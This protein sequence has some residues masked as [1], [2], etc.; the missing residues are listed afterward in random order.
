M[1]RRT[2]EGMGGARLGTGRRLGSQ[3]W[4]PPEG[5]WPQVLARDLLSTSTMATAMRCSDL[6]RRDHELIGEVVAEVATLTARLREGTDAPVSALAGAIEFFTAFVSGV[7]AAREERGLMPVLAR[8]GAAMPRAL[9]HEHEEGRRLLR[10]LHAVAARRQLDGHRLMRLNDYLAFLRRHLATADASLLPLADHLSAGEEAEVRE[11]F[12]RIDEEAG[13]P[14][15]LATLLAGYWRTGWLSEPGSV[16][17]AYGRGWLA[18]HGLGRR[19]R[20]Q[21]RLRL[22]FSRRAGR[23]HACIR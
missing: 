14:E 22:A 7:H 21:V 4:E 11:A 13:G 6:L 16:L 17:E 15:R 20:K 3:G 18:V 10:A 1:T 8:H 12:D 2:G 23:G 19:R 5:S 9:R